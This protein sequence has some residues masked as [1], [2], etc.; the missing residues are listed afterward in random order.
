LYA[1]VP[2]TGTDNGD[3]TIAATSKDGF[4][5]GYTLNGENY[6]VT[7][8]VVT[9]YSAVAIPFEKTGVDLTVWDAYMKE[10]NVSYEYDP[11]NNPGWTV[12]YKERV[13]KGDDNVFNYRIP[14]DKTFIITQS[15]EKTFDLL[16]VA[17]SGNKD[18]DVSLTLDNVRLGEKCYFEIKDGA[19][20]ALTLIKENK[21]GMLDLNTPYTKKGEGTW[22][23]DE[24]NVGGKVTTTANADY[25]DENTVKYFA[26]YNIDED[27]TLKSLSIYQGGKVNIADGKKLKVTNTNRPVYVGSEGTLSV[28]KGSEL[29]VE[30]TSAGGDIISVSGGNLIIGE[31]ATVTTK[32]YKNSTA[33]SLSSSNQWGNQ[34]PNSNVIIGEGASL[35]LNGGIEN[36]LSKGLSIECYMGASATIDLAKGATLSAL[37][38]TNGAIYCYSS[39]WRGSLSSKAKPCNITFNIAEGAKV[40]ANETDTGYGFYYSGSVSGE[41]PT[42]IL[43]ITGKGAFEAKSATGTGMILN[44]KINITGVDVT[45][46]GGTEK[47]AIKTFA[48]TDLTLTYSK[49]SATK[50][51]AKAGTGSTICIADADD[52]EL[53]KFAEASY[54]DTTADGVRTITPKAPTE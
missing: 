13:D 8:G 27:F 16:N 3:I 40:I 42:P 46:T 37:G 39:D 6:P 36:T 33:L 20:F 31:K 44:D 30:A 5:R 34:N 28:G 11:I 10:N 48:T 41:V 50:L 43:N 53:A 1:A 29:F 21:F 14:D 49:D 24:L 32:G 54:T 9:D 22:K 2:A 4:M 26:E 52:K 47:P 15:G 25:E 45:A 17:I 38:I 51:T 18:K 12:K 35:E 7:K 19:K 23:F